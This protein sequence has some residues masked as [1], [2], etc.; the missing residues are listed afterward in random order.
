MTVEASEN[1]VFSRSVISFTKKKYNQVDR[2]KNMENNNR[3]KV[4][5][6][7]KWTRKWK[8]FQ[9]TFWWNLWVFPKIGVPQN[10]WFIMEN[11]IEMDDLGVPLFSETSLFWIATTCH[12]FVFPFKR[13]ATS[14]ASSAAPSALFMVSWLLGTT[15]WNPM[16]NNGIYIQYIWEPDFGNGWSEKGRDL[17]C[18]MLNPFGCVRWYV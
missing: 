5:S 6:N 18:L 14:S 13:L 4:L 17:G 9:K 11:P 12:F 1:W 2:R 3:K 16:K 7:I 15:L 10:G 8:I